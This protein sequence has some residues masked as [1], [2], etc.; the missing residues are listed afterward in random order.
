M[1]YTNR[2]IHRGQKEMNGCQL[3]QGGGNGSDGLVNMEFS[4]PYNSE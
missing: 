4:S 3:L 2:Q 1:N